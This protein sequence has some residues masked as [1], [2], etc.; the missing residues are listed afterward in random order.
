VVEILV[1]DVCLMR[2]SRETLSAELRLEA[3]ETKK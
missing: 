1:E 2:P 3:L